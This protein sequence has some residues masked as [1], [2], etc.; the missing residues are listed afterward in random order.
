METVWCVLKTAWAAILIALLCVPILAACAGKIPEIKGE[1]KI[2]FVDEKKGG[3]EE[4][5]HTVNTE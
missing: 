5:I 2:E 1:I 3:T 4:N